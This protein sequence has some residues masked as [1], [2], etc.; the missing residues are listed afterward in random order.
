MLFF[1]VL[2]LIGH[3]I[4]VFIYRIETGS[5]NTIR[6][7]EPGGYRLAVAG[8]T[9]GWLGNRIASRVPNAYFLIFGSGG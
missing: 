1:T 3:E 8:M 7:P 4:V 5:E 2:L 9:I 6:R